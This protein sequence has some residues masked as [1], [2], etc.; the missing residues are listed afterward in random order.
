M[1]GQS[2]LERGWLA[3]TRGNPTYIGSTKVVVEDKIFREGG[4]A[5]NFPPEKG[6]LQSMLA[7]QYGV[8][9]CWMK[10]L[11]V[12]VL[13][14]ETRNVRV[15]SPSIHPRVVHLKKL[16]LIQGKWISQ[17]H[18]TRSRPRLKPASLFHLLPHQRNEERGKE[19]EGAGVE[20]CKHME[21]VLCF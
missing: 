12:E 11:S 9:R 18:T 5:S 14:G 21:Q 3:W 7:F 8:C 10:R 1:W 2:K 15:P 6:D 20:G 19:R 16:R 17:S 4:L 13:P